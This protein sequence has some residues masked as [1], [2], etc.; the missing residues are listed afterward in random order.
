[1]KVILLA[2]MS[3]N[4]YIAER[5]DQSSLDW[6]SKEDTKFFVEKTKEIGALIMGRRTY[7][8]IGRPLPGRLTVV[9]SRTPADFPSQPDVLEFTTAEPTEILRK[10]EERGFS[11]VVIAG[12]ASVYSAFL[13]LGLVDEL[14]LTIEPVLFGAGIP[15][16]EGFARMNVE[17][18]GTKQ[19]GNRAVL[20][21]YK[22]I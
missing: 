3:A 14:Y 10:L 4:G 21:H 15:L 13:S 16:A 1:M 22:K 7:E 5:A 2:A 9:M 18:V 12:G 11:Q 6:T 20:L 8:T 19:L 17:L